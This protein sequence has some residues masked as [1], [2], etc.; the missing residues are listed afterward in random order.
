MKSALTFAR[1]FI[2]ARWP[3]INSRA[4]LDAWQAQMI[5]RHLDWVC[6]H[7]PFY[8][9]YQ[10]Q[11]LS[12]FPIMD[13][14]TM[15]DNLDAINTQGLKSE[16]LMPLA[17]NAEQ[18][19]EFSSSVCKGVTVGLSSGTSGRRGLFLANDAERQLWAAAITG[20]MLP[21]LLSKHRIALLLRADSPLYHSVKRR[22]VQF[23]YCDLTQPL[24]Q[25]LPALEAFDPTLMVGSAQALMLAAEHH[26]QLKPNRVISGAEVLTPTDKH[27]LGDKLGCDIHEIYQCTEGFLA[28][29][30]RHGVMRWN[31]DLVYIEREWL[32]EEKTHY[33]PIITDFRRTTQPVIRYR[34]D[35]VI[36]HKEDDGIF[37]PIEAIVGRCGDRFLLPPLSCDAN[38]EQ[39]ANEQSA[40][41]QRTTLPESTE[42]LTTHDP[43]TLLPDLIA[44]AVTL[45]VDGQ[46]NYRIT[47]T[48]INTVHIEAPE[49]HQP[50][51][52]T[53]LSRL[54]SQQGCAQTVFTFA[55]EP[56]WQPDIKQRRV[57]NACHTPS[58]LTVQMT[59]QGAQQ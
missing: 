34:L 20:K 53:S 39:N 57:V 46:C 44:R 52:A 55:S 10:G 13:K 59:A 22:R 28:C 50:H 30:D 26:T 33:V 21:S 32:N 3:G 1:Q 24:S 16:I 38:K 31:E 17:L 45:A 47:Q 19:R 51:I 29:S 11:P 14:A 36:E 4:K 23:H 2:Q 27:W 48:G 12:A 37:A 40:M 9:A 25:W 54:F 42:L 7:S 49:A 18:S 5:Q 58:Q 43:I 15:M 41:L 35:D 8:A 56:Q 6:A